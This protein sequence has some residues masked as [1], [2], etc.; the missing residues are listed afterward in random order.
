MAEKRPLGAR[1][2]GDQFPLDLFRIGLPRESE[3]LSQ[4]RDVRIHD[5]ALIQPERVA[6]DD[7]GRLAP[8]TVELGE[9]I[10]RAHV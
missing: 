3:T 6:E 10:G 9:E 8:H 4:P 1:N 2:E 5:D 7:I